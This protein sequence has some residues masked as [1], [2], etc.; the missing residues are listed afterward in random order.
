[1]RILAITEAGNR[2]PWSSAAEIN[3]LAVNELPAAPTSLGAW[4]PTV[5]FPLVPAAIALLD[6]GNLLAWSSYAADI[7]TGGADD[8]TI[9]STYVPTT[10]TVTEAI[11]TN[12]GHDM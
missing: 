12:T 10:G 9:T 6:N 4:G 3:I 11:I 1:M 7:F 5:I 2:G 8:M